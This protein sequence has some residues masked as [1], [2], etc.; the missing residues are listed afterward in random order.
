MIKRILEAAAQGIAD[1]TSK[2]PFLY[3]LGPDGARKVLDDSAGPCGP[4]RGSLHSSG[5]DQTCPRSTRSGSPC[6]LRSATYR[7]ASSSPSVPK[8]RCPPSCTS[9]AA[10][11]SSV[12][13]EPTTAS[14][15]NSPSASTPRPCSSST[16]APRRARYLVAIEQAY[17][18]AQWIT[19]HGP[20]EGLNPLSH[21]RNQEPSSATS[22]GLIRKVNASRVMTV[23]C[24]VGGYG[25]DQ[26]DHRAHG[27]ARFGEAAA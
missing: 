9:T 8:A 15:A 23:S 18:T 22:A 11:G 27:S 19:Q 3:Q 10:A 1:A 6:P 14:S 13:P 24:T 12:T 16:T 26:F 17:A 7:S 25:W 4:H 5:A 21:L 2:P 20:V